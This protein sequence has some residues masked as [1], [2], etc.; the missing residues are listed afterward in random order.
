LELVDK[1]RET[2]NIVLHK[3]SLA[4]AIELAKKEFMLI[5]I[6]MG[7]QCTAKFRPLHCFELFSNRLNPA[8]HGAS[9]ES[10]QQDQPNT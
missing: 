5:T 2:I 10:R 3:R 7:M 8:L 6:K 4:D 9:T 1:L